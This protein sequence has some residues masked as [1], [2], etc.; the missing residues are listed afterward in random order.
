MSVLAWLTST[1]ESLLLE[2]VA[3]VRSLVA[4]QAARAR[5]LTPATTEVTTRRVRRRMAGVVVMA[6]PWGESGEGG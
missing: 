6:G 3:E 4:P 2:L 1:V 5:A